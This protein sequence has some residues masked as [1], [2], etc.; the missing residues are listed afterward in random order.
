MSHAVAAPY[1]RAARH[2]R[3]PHLL[4]VGKAYG[5][6]LTAVRRDWAWPD[7]IDALL[8]LDAESASRAAASAERE[9]ARGR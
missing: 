8:E 4:R 9:A 5:C 3:A 1:Q 2:F 6:G 7:V